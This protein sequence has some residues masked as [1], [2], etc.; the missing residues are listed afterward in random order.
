M[1]TRFTGFYFTEDGTVPAAVTALE[2]GP[3]PGP[4][5]LRLIP[6][7]RHLVPN[8][9]GLTGW[10]HTGRLFALYGA[11]HGTLYLARPDG[12]VLGRWRTAVS[13]EL[14]NAIEHTQQR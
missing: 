2:T 9:P 6:I 10:D 1:T 12:H 5:L 8:G 11:Q 14:A 7:T 3:F 4:G 13:S